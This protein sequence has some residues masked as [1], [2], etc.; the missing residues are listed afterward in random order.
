M[1]EP[2]VLV[3]G[4]AGGIGGATARRFAASGWRVVATDRDA[5]GLGPAGR[6]ARAGAGGRA[7]RPT[8]SEV[9]ECRGAVATPSRP[10]AASTA[11]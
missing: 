11:W 6:G 1:A 3:S 9:D 5:A 7:S 8:F 10:R 4:A 2:V